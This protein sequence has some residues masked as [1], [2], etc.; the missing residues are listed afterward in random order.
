LAGINGFGHLA[1]KVQDLDASLAFYRDRLGLGEM[2]RLVDGKGAPW[3]V[4]LRITDTVFLELFPSGH[5]GRAADEAAVGVNHIC[6]SVEDIEAT[7]ARF[8]AAGVTLTSPIQTGLD[9]NRGAWI[10][11]PDGNRIELMEMAADCLQYR[12]ISALPA[13]R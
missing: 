7:A 11:D 2:T 3:I 5:P 13:N 10:E 1:F 8:A 4:Y 6:F 12:A 9:G